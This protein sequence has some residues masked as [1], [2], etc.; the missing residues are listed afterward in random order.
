MTE[1]VEVEDIDG[2]V[3]LK[4][5]RPERRNALN[6]KICREL[7]WKIREVETR[8]GAVILTGEGKAFSAGGDVKEMAE[9]S[10][11]KAY[12]RRLAEAIH[13]VIR[14]IKSSRHGFIAAING[15]A[16]GAGMCL[17]LAC[18]IKIASRN[19]NLSTGYLKIGLAPGCGTWFLATHLPFS[20]A[21]DLLITN[22]SITPVEACEMGL[23]NE[24][25]DSGE[26]MDAALRWA[27]LLRK[28][29]STA[30]SRAKY[31]L[32]RAYANKLEDHLKL[33]AA[34]LEASGGTWE[35]RE[36]V[37]AF[38]EKRRPC[39]DKSTIDEHLHDIRQSF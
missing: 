20:R 35:F 12:L 19:S 21:M 2:T 7:T 33:E 39:F 22:R 38:S 17:A 36:G 27:D 26:L 37:D 29:P 13:G 6:V 9:A 5:N 24:V 4:L 11:Q 32:N 14:A 16:V 30:F 1:L 23:I 10:D 15:N 18:D 8:T 34:F 25:V 3:V 31:L 28:S